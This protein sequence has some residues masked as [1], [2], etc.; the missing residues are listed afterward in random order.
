MTHT[1]TEL[2]INVSGGRIVNAKITSLSTCK[3]TIE[4]QPDVGMTPKIDVP[5]NSKCSSF[6]LVNVSTLTVNDDFMQ[7]KPK[8]YLEWKFKDDLSSALEANLEDFYCP[9]INPSFAKPDGIC[10]IPG[11]KPA[12]KKSPDWWETQAKAFLPEYDSRLGTKNEYLAFLGFLIKRLLTRGYSLD[13]AWHDVY[14]DSRDLGHY[15]NS[16]KAKSK[17]E[18]TGSREICGFCDLASTKKILAEYTKTMEPSQ[19]LLSSGNCCDLSD[20]APLAT[21]TPLK[22]RQNSQSCGNATG[23]ITFRIPKENTF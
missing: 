12:I 14:L 9:T 2:E 11:N 4:M 1:S 16:K 8:S 7:Y 18:R 5:I 3:L 10:Y 13:K 21:L 19:F 17:P 22:A 15:K 20:K 23:W 6:A